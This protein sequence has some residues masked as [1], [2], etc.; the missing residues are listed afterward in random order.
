MHHLYEPIPFWL[1]FVCYSRGPKRYDYIDEQ[2]IYSHD[3]VAMLTLLTDE[4]SQAL[5]E[6]IDFSECQT[7]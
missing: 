2:W 3:G 1:H 6:N 5:N 4:I 7:D